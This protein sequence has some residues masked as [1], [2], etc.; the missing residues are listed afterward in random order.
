MFS[1]IKRLFQYFIIKESNSQPSSSSFL[2]FSSD[3]ADF[4][5]K[6]REE[7]LKLQQQMDALL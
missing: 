4:F 2:F 6:A 1:P 3:K 5:E 7:A